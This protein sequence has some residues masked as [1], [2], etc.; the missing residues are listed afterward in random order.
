MLPPPRLANNDGTLHE[1][2]ERCK[3]Q[4]NILVASGFMNR[5]VESEKWTAYLFRFDQNKAT[6]DLNWALQYWLSKREPIPEKRYRRKCAACS[7]NALGLC[8][9][10]L[11]E[12]DSNFTVQ[13]LPDG[14]AVVR[15]Q[16]HATLLF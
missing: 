11:Q 3:E 8:D 9:H 14:R 10:A 13:R 15:R 1:I 2:H 4:S 5:K 12:P 6:T 16:E 7:I